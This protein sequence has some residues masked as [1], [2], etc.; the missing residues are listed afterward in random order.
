MKELA[1]GTPGA[2]SLQ[3]VIANGFR[4]SGSSL[5]SPGT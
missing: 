3:E 5:G 2:L 1:T 4:A